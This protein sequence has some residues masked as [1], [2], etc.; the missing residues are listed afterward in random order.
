MKGAFLLKLEENMKE[1][2]IKILKIII[3]SIS[4]IIVAAF[5]ITYN[6]GLSNGVGAGKDEGII[7]GKEIQQQDNQKLMQEAFGNIVNV[8]GDNNEVNINDLKKISD[9]YINLKEEYSELQ[10]QNISLTDQHLID[11]NTISEKEK[12]IDNL[13]SQIND[14]PVFD[15]KNLTLSVDGQQIPINSNNSTVTIDGRDYMSKEIVQALI[16]SD[17]NLYVKD[18]T[19][20][21]GKVIADRSNL[22]DKW[23]IDKNCPDY[24]SATDSYGNSYS[25]ALVVS[26]DNT[27]IYNLSRNYTQL[28]FSLA[29]TDKS[30]LNTKGKLIVKADE[31]IV[32]T[33]PALDKMTE[34]FETPPIP[35]ENCSSLTI[36][37]SSEYG[38]RCIISDAI[39]Y[40]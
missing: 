1:K 7:I 35:I 24:D 38:N 40:N 11:I 9:D 27:I 31:N 3:P 17:K 2:T 16:S 8:E 22:F 29:I 34:V 19:I 32:Y 13:K 21:V 20:F 39:V 12:E 6:I 37:Y 30:Y 18:K 4:A 26:N 36:T 14:S 28:K 15:Y 10:S 33:S 25:K 23:I 5:P